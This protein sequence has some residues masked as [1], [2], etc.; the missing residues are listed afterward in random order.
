VPA[1]VHHL[2]DHLKENDRMLA[3]TPLDDRHMHIDVTE[4][5]AGLRRGRGTWENDV[6][7]AVARRIIEGCLMGYDTE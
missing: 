5:L 4:V 7:E 3:L 1:K 6:P 2:L